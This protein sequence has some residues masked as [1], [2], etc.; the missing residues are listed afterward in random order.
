MGVRVERPVRLGR[1]G[2]VLQLHDW[3]YCDNGRN[4]KTQAG[5][6]VNGFQSCN[7]RS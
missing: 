5:A 1:E 2:K 7:I 3:P 4:M 6:F